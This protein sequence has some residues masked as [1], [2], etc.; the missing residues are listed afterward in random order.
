MRK[1]RCAPWY[2]GKNQ[3]RFVQLSED[4]GFITTEDASTATT[5]GES[6]VEE[7]IWELALTTTPSQ[8]YVWE[9]IGW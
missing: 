9:R 6:V 3:H 5:P 2:E 8:H 4:E 7:D 1:E